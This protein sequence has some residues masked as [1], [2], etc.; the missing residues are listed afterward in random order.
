MG[1]DNWRFL[2][3]PSLLFSTLSLSLSRCL[4]PSHTYLWLTSFFKGSVGCAQALRRAPRR[5]RSCFQPWR[6]AG[7]ASRAYGG[8]PPSELDAAADIG[9]KGIALP[10]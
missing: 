4:S 5:K 1:A 9:I 8:G 3:S 2:Y 10:S 6:V 7:L